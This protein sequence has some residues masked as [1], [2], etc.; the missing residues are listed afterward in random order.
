MTEG[1]DF[2][3]ELAHVR[4]IHITPIFASPEGEGFPPSP[5]V[6]LKVLLSHSNNFYIKEVMKE[7]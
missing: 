7:Y 1:G 3:L 4:L 5:M 6:T 2:F